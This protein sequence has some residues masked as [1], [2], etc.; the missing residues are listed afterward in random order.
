MECEIAKLTALSLA[1]DIA[2]LMLLHSAAGSITF[3][4]AL[5]RVAR[6][7]KPTLNAFEPSEFIWVLKIKTS[8]SSCKQNVSLSQIQTFVSVKVFFPLMVLRM[9]LFGIA[10]L[11]AIALFMRVWKSLPWWCPLR[12]SSIRRLVSRLRSDAGAWSPCLPIQSIPKCRSFKGGNCREECV[13]CDQCVKSSSPES[14][15][16]PRPVLSWNQ[17]RLRFHDHLAEGYQDTIHTECIPVPHSLEVTLGLWQKPRVWYV[18]HLACLQPVHH[19][20]LSQGHVS[21]W[22]Q[23]QTYPNIPFHDVLWKIMKATLQIFRLF[24]LQ[25][26]FKLFNL[27]WAG[28]SPWRSRQWAILS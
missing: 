7:C 18:K 5:Q 2:H 23:L 15:K 24:S 22:Q 1:L 26:N 17:K 3:L 10:R 27:V 8:G 14:R 16:C 6:M 12:S 11:V 13:E 20:T 19:S 9:R 4:Y 28:E 25:A 21:G